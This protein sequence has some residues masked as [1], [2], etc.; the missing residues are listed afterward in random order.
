MD[1]ITAPVK[2]AALSQQVEAA[3]RTMGEKILRKAAEQAETQTERDEPREE[4]AQ[5][6]QTQEKKPAGSR[7]IHVLRVREVVTV[8][9]VA[10]FEDWDKIKEKLDT[11]VRELL[12][13]GLQVELS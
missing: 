5:P 13:Q 4:D 11:R 1:E 8:T 2:A 12:N 7:Q 6:S 3:I 10:T 9:R